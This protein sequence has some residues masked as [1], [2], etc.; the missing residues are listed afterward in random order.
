[1]YTSQGEDA[2]ITDVPRAVIDVLRVVCPEML[3]VIDK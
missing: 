3:V 1:M 2:L